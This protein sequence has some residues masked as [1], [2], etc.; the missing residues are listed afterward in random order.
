MIPA[1]FEYHR[2]G[3]IASAIG[4]LQEHGDEARVIAGGHSLIPMMKLRM[5]DMSHLVDLQAIEE[6][7]G[8]EIES[9]IV[10]LG[11][12]VTQHELITHDG[13]ASAIP[14]IREAA[15]QIA[16]PQVRYVGTVG[17]NVANGDPG[18]DMPG[19]MQCLNATFELSGPDG[20][21]SVA[22]REFYEAAYFT[23]REEEEI[24]TRISIPKPG[25]GIGQAYE[26]QKRKIGDY[27]TAAAAVMVGNGTASVAM[28]NLADTPIWS[29]DASNA[30]AGGD[31]EGCVAA[32]LDAIDP[33][34]DNRGPVEFKKHVAAVMLRRAIDRAQNRAG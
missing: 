22:A 27:A 24:L 17:G 4:I 29:E 16:D 19:L 23:A 18:N 1:G 5:T 20:N 2:P 26:K 9:D 33:V 15:L 31:V 7:K 25:A 8:I 21:R 14:L 10:T 13:L 3:D 32:M 12:M 28:T 11:A 34:A 30:L 6:L